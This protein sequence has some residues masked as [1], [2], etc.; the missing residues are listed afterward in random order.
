FGDRVNATPLAIATVYAS[1]GSGRIVRPT[2]VKVPRTGPCPKDRA[3]AD[4]CMPLLPAGRTADEMLAR[5]RAGLHAVASVRGSPGGTAAAVFNDA[6][7]RD[8]L[9]ANGVP[10]LFVKTGTAT[11]IRNK[12]FSLWTAGWI[13]GSDSGIRSRMAFACF[14]TY[15][16]NSDTGGGTC[17]K[18]V[19]D[20]LVRL[21]D[22]RQTP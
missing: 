1:V 18:L 9:R 2:I 21:K 10:M 12:R 22:G 6:T 16:R 4:E 13:E 8:L 5:L 3:D 20:F 17:A 14:I 11:I 19:A 15:G 7:H